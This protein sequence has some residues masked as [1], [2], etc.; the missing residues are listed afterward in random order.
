[1]A[2]NEALELLPLVAARDLDRDD[3]QRHLS[4]LQGLGSS[5]AAWSDD[6]ETAWSALEQGR[7]VLISQSLELAVDAELHALHPELAQRAHEIRSILNRGVGID[8]PVSRHR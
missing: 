5:A 1:R 8:N 2:W 3:R 6:P 4:L 7:G